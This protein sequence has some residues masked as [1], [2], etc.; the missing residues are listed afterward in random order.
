MIK[1]IIICVLS[2][3][4]LLNAMDKPAEF[5]AFEQK[6]SECL[7]TC[8]FGTSVFCAAAT[9]CAQADAFKILCDKFLIPYPL[10][11]ILTG[12]TAVCTCFYGFSKD[13]SS[14]PTN[15]TFARAIRNRKKLILLAETLK[16]KETE[17]STAGQILVHRTAGSMDTE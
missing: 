14:K 16:Q 12:T 5:R 8:C 15:R 4:Y 11:S 7:L 3:Y 6:P 13:S 17:E 1:K 2:C 9:C 10:V